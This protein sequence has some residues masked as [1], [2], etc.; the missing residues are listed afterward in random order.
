MKLAT[1]GCPTGPDRR[2]VGRAS[3]ARI[4]SG[5]EAV[6]PDRLITSARL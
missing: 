4:S 6:S 2:I 3:R 1:I 5:I